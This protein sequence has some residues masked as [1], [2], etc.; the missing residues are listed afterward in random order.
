MFF[1]AFGADPGP[2]G[3]GIH[4]VKQILTTHCELSVLER[5]EELLT[6]RCEFP[7]GVC[8]CHRWT[9]RLLVRGAWAGS[10]RRPPGYSRTL[11]EQGAMRLFPAPRGSPAAAPGGSV[12]P[13]VLSLQFCAELNQPV[14][15]N[16][17]KWKGPR[18]SWKA[19]VADSPST[20][21]QKV[22]SP[23]GLAFASHCSEA[24]FCPNH[25]II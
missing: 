22:P 10:P 25:G 24:P 6:V 3:L 8:T 19:V 18:G 11:S 13:P 1:S 5:D 23:A 21:L 7:G 9:G 2:L 4:R 20:P 17:R 12:R 15:P 14:L 16:I